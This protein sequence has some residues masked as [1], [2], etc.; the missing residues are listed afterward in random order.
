[1]TDCIKRSS[2]SFR[3]IRIEPIFLRFYRSALA[4][5]GPSGIALGDKAVD[6]ADLC[7]CDEIIGAVGAQTIG[8]GKLT[9]EM[10]KVETGRNGRELINNHLRPFALNSSDNSIPVEGIEQQRFRSHGV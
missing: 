2:K 10:P 3:R 7:G 6:L 5:I 1:M 8:L 4:C 9:V